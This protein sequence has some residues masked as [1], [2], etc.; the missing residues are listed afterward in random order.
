MS[1]LGHLFRALIVAFI[2]LKAFA[3][4]VIHAILPFVFVHNV[5]KIIEALHIELNHGQE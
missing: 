2:L 3:M 1:Y 4:I 5:S